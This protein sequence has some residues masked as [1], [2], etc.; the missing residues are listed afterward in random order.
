MLYVPA[1][2]EMKDFHYSSI[3]QDHQCYKFPQELLDPQVSHL[4]PQHLQHE[5]ASLLQ[6]RNLSQL[7]TKN[8]NTW[9]QDSWSSR[10][11][12]S[13]TLDSYKIDLEAKAQVCVRKLEI[14][15]SK[16]FWKHLGKLLWRYKNFQHKNHFSKNFFSKTFFK[17]QKL[18]E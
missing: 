11:T 7:I 5:L 3:S 12:L 17:T 15:E 1:F 13:Q 18:E 9:D 8:E 10:K 6:G 14:L 16:L 4:A 2:T